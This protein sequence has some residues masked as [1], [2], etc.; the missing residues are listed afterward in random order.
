[1]AIFIIAVIADLY[2]DY[3]NISS[4]SVDLLLISVCLSSGSYTAPFWVYSTFIAS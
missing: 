3:S 2:R 1:M 4:L